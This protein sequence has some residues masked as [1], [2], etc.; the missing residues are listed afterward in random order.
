MSSDSLGEL[1]E[2]KRRDQ[3]VDFILAFNVINH[4]PGYE[5]LISDALKSKTS[6]ALWELSAKTTRSPNGPI[7]N[8]KSF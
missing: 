4:V 3:P 6:N 7:L 2:S 5:V 1:D 8:C